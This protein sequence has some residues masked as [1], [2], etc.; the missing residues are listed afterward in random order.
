MLLAMADPEDREA[1]PLSGIVLA[2]VDPAVRGVLEA[3]AA[4]ERTLEGI[5]TASRQAWP[6]ID[7]PADTFVSYLADRLSET[8]ADP[9]A[10]LR[11]DQLY[12]ACAC[13]LGID[14]AIEAFERDV[15]PAVRAP[16]ARLSKTGT[17]AED[18]TQ[19]L[20]ARLLV[21]SLEKP[22]KILEFMGRG[23]LKGW[24][25]VAATR[26][27]L[28]RLR[29]RKR[30]VEL[31][32][33]EVAGHVEDAEL[34][35]LKESYSAEFKSAFSAALTT[36]SPKER[37]LLR[38]NVIDDL[39][40]DAIGRMY[41]VHRA[42]AARWLAAARDRLADETKVRLRATLKIDQPELESVIRLIRSR[43]D[44]SLRRLFDD[45]K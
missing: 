2:R 26:L 34:A 20:R 32:D 30:E 40:I 8:A 11:T 45:E 38:L 39:G 44:L 41:N 23:T 13:A 16:L 17:L 21:G 36:L 6:A 35:R 37:N 4:L 15:F 42:T 10:E 7:L 29:D 5:V 31:D 43:I 33:L 24:L 25:R 27:A 18:I 28:N 12:L 22:A 3:N 1:A 9:F 19:E 14:S